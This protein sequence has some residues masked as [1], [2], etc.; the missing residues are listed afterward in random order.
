M[1]SVG[2]AAS[3]GIA[4]GSIE[5]DTKS[6]SSVEAAARGVGQSVAQ[7]LGAIDAATKRNQ[8]SFSELAKGAQQLQGQL[9]GIGIGA[10]LTTAFGLGAARDLRNYTVAF[11]QFTGSQKES[12]KLMDELTTKANQFGLDM[13][14]V[15]QLGRALIPVLKGNTDELDKWVT[16]AALLSST[17]PLKSTAEAARAIQEYL[18]G[19]PISLQRLFNV[20]PALIKEAQSQFQDLGQQLD[21]ILRKMGATEE[22]AAAMSDQ[23]Q[24]LKNELR[25][26][27]AEGFTPLLR[28]LTPTLQGLTAVV[29]AFNHAAPATATFGAGLTALVAVGAPALILLNQLAQAQERLAKAG[30]LASALGTAGKIGVGI[31]AGVVGIDVGVGIGNA[32]NRARGVPEADSA[33]LL[34]SL[35]QL[36]FSVEAIL[37]KVMQTLERALTDASVAFINAIVNA[38]DALASFSSALASFLPGSLG[39]GA[40]SNAER[41]TGIGD[42]LHMLAAEISRGTATAIAEQNEK[43]ATEARQIQQSNPADQKART[44]QADIDTSANDIKRQWYDSVRKIELQANEERIQATQQYESQRTQVIAQ[45]ETAVARDAEDFGRQRAREEQQLAKQLADIQA[46][47]GIRE[48]QWARDLAD[49]IEAET[50]ASNQRIAQIEA[51]SARN[52][53]KIQTDSAKNIGKIEQD[54]DKNISKIETDSAKD[55]AKITEDSNKN[56]AKIEDDYAKQREKALQQHNDNL[57]TAAGNLDAKAVAAEQRRYAQEQTDATTA[58]ADQIKQEQDAA[59]ERIKQAQETEAERIQAEKD[60]AADR[61]KNERESAAERIQAERESMAESIAQE[62][63]SLAQRISEE[64]AANDK[65]IQ[66]A[67]EADLQRETDLKASLAEQQKQEDEDR[68]IRLQRMAE[69]HQRQLDELDRAH[70]ERIAQINQQQADERRKLDDEFLKQL[71]Q[72]GI[73][74]DQWLKLQKAQQ[75]AALKSFEDWWKKIN[76]KLKDFAPLSDDPAKFF[77]GFQEW[78]QEFSKYFELK[79]QNPNGPGFANGGPVTHTGYALVHQG[80]F[81]LSNAMLTQ[82]RNPMA[83]TTNSSALT[84]ADGAIRIYAAPGQNAGDIAAAVRGELMNIFGGMN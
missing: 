48:L 76:D 34:Y 5:I 18:A 81:V 14:E 11:T 27:L 71:D 80:E 24:S 29:A 4:R 84:I 64:Q 25:L 57:F 35:R 42:T 44:Q 51:Q 73:H 83:M 28:V 43:L 66:D 19:Q 39:K 36:L 15:W 2:G 26:L 75:D 10:G 3:L 67:R 1:P 9:T 8:A 20:N 32:I 6:L 17:N 30:A 31:G 74:N 22:G 33:Q 60:A 52:I 50:N 49:N 56:L 82:M 78:I 59:A 72:L 63:A 40:E 79:Q 21:F 12:S 45:Y 41:Y 69:D 37:S 61:I 23:F 58:H 53:E 65:R 47:Q 13:T 55:I 7:S 68:A 16:R 46:E 62:R 77:A 54:R 70:T 38:V